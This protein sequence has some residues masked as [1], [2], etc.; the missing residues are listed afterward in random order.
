M[1]MWKQK[2]NQIF[3]KQK[4]RRGR[5]SNS[6]DF[7]DPFYI[8]WRKQV[9]K[10]DNYTCQ[11]PGCD[12]TARKGDNRRRALGL[13]AHH[14]LTWAEYPSL[15]FN[16]QNGITLCRRAHDLIKG[17]ENLYVK[18]F[19]QIVMQNSMEQTKKS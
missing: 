12:C 15:R 1:Q 4:F 3:S 16:V 11:F 17:K 5:I 8:N 10:R 13:Q 19:S 7:R 9:Y 18:A 14:I 6:R 2:K